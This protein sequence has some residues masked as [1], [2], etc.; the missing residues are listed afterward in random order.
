MRPCA[1]RTGT[2]S[3]TGLS[4]LNRKSERI[5]RSANPAGL[6]GASKPPV[7]SFGIFGSLR[8][9]AKSGPKAPKEL[10]ILESGLT[11][12]LFQELLNVIVVH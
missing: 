10:A 3:S 11:V 7:K 5:P 9:A 12:S 8:Y 4:L 6:R 1:T 2:F